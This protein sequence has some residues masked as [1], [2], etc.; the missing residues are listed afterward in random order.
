[1]KRWLLL[2]AIGVTLVTGAGTAA[3]LKADSGNPVVFLSPELASV[4]PNFHPHPD[5][6]RVYYA[7]SLKQ[8]RGWAKYTSI[9]YNLCPNNCEYD[10]RK[11]GVFVIFYKGQV[12]RIEG[13]FD[14]RI[15]DIEE[16]AAAELSAKV[17]AACYAP[18]C[19]EAQADPSDHQWGMYILVRIVKKSLLVPPK[20]V[21][22]TTALP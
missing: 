17:T 19:K 22:V 18:A 20:T 8:A 7:G 4:D 15:D 12:D 3:P 2:P 11:Y 13:G 1:M 6:N 5:R 14:P 21:R 9:P 16:S 10:F